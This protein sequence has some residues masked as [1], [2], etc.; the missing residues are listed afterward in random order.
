M[1]ELDEKRAWHEWSLAFANDRVAL[2]AAPPAPDPREALAAR[3]LLEAV[4]RMGDRIGQHTVSEITV[5]SDRA[6]AWLAENP[7][8][9]PVAIEPRG[10]PAPGACSCVEPPA[11]APP[12]DHIPAATKMVGDGD[13]E[14]E[15]LAAL[16]E[17][18]ADAHNGLWP[19][20]IVGR[21]YRAAYLLRQPAPSPSADGPAVPEGREPAAVAQQGSA[22]PAADGEREELAADLD[23][24]A[25]S[26]VLAEKHNWAKHMRRA[27]ALLRQPTPTAEEIEA[28]FR[29]WWSASYPSAPAGPH[30]VASHVAFALHL[31]DRGVQ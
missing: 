24:C 19:G 27:A 30:A 28:Q 23:E 13:G 20:L 18:T 2:A 7:P 21:F 16:I 8:G 17:A 26:C 15:E 31:L 25:A 29:A 1:E 11:P 5:I 10:C 6:A 9:Q 22:P 4:A 12:P 3:P 14:R